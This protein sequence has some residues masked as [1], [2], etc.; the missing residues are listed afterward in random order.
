MSDAQTAG[1]LQNQQLAAKQE[2]ERTRKENLK[3]SRVEIKL[4]GG[5]RILP[6]PE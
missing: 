4:D 3:V 5:V 1:S 6:L 2:I